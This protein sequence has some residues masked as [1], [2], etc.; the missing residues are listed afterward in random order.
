MYIIQVNRKAFKLLYRK[1][2]QDNAYQILS[3]LTGFYSKY[4]K[5]IWVCFFRFTV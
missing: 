4:D 5:N 1:F 2:I 3:E